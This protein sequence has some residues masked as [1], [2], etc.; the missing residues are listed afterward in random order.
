MN[1]Q[2]IGAKADCIFSMVATE[3]LQRSRVARASS[4][5]VNVIVNRSVGS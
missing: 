2:A 3:D 5:I 4:V 1:S